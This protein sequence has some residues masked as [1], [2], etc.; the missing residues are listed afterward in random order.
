[1]NSNIDFVTRAHAL[2]RVRMAQWQQQN[3]A[4]QQQG[5]APLPPPNLITIWE[6]K[7]SA[8]PNK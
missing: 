1:M 6:R 7:P 8:P 2:W 3:Q 5:K 4:L